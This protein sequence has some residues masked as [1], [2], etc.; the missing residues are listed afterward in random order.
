[1]ESS[2]SESVQQMVRPGKC[3]DLYYPDPETAHKQCFR[4]TQ[5]TRY[6]QQFANLTGGSSVFTIPPNNGLQDIVLTM[7]LPVSGTGGF[8]ASGLAV[9]RGWGYAAI[10]Q[11]S[12]RYGGSS[13]YFLSGQQLLQAA[14]RKAPNSG[15][16]DQLLALGGSA[17]AGAAAA[18]GDFAAP[19]RAYVWLALPHTTPSADGKLPPLPTDLN[20]MVACY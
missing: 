14:L 7:E 9:P 15:A 4:T 17:A 19:Q 1:M 20:N 11:V 3:V 5:N 12:F 18:A 6:V 16:R 13:Q 10:K 8:V 2:L